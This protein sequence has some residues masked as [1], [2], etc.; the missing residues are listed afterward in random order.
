[1]KILSKLLGAASAAVI[2][3]AVPA[4]V[5][6]LSP[7]VTASAANAGNSLTGNDLAIYN[8]A[9][10]YYAGVAAGTTSETKFTYTFEGYKSD[11][12]WTAS[13]LA[14][15]GINTDTLTEDIISNFMTKVDERCAVDSQKVV[16]ALLAD[17]PYEFYWI[18]NSVDY[19]LGSSGIGVQMYGNST[20]NP[21]L[22]SVGLMSSKSFICAG[23]VSETQ[24]FWILKN[25]IQDNI[26]FFQSVR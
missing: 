25:Q 4:F 18:D 12:H 15:Y 1:M 13:D 8:A 3:A 16:K 7:V 24:Q 23:S 17:C 5:P 26:H 14:D 10:N 6:S 2:L 22:H 11:K 9:K 20:K 19:T 21:Y